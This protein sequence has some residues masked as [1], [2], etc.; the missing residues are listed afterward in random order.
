VLL[1]ELAASWCLVGGRSC[2]VL[3]GDV[4]C[5]S[6]VAGS[7]ETDLLNPQGLRGSVE[8]D[9]ENPQGLRGSVETDLVH[10]Q[11]LPRSVETDVV[12]AERVL[13]L[14]SNRRGEACG[15]AL[16]G[17][18]RCFWVAKHRVPVPSGWRWRALERWA[19]EQ[20]GWSSRR[21]KSQNRRIA[22]PLEGW[23]AVATCQACAV[24]P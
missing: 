22:G 21:I 17:S 6:Q 15:A 24:L 16:V 13:P 4:V 12:K 23:V 19:R 3:K 9:V 14:G 20:T 18:N 5:W 2:N 8:T 10:P 1:L 7:V 11:G